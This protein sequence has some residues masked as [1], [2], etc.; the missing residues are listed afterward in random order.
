[1]RIKLVW[2][3]CDYRN[4]EWGKY[5]LVDC[6]WVEATIE[7]SEKYVFSCMSKSAKKIFQEVE[8]ESSFRKAIKSYY[9]DDAKAE[10]TWCGMCAR[11]FFLVAKDLSSIDPHCSY[12]PFSGM[13]N[14]RSPFKNI[15][16][17]GI[18]RLGDIKRIQSYNILRGQLRDV[19]DAL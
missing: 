13:W 16:A 4:R 1:M 7:E 8:G 12:Y 11:Y 14:G 9:R 19:E 10:G 6:F 3:N 5:P 2:P 15:E 17:M 18:R